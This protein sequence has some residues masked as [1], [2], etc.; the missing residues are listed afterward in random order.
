MWWESEAGKK[1]REG[2]ITLCRVVKEGPSE[3][4][5]FEL[6]GERRDRGSRQDMTKGTP[7]RGNRK[8]KGPEQGV[9]TVC[10]WK[11][12]EASAAGQ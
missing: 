5:A 11:S 7:G 8:S 2:N 9:Y 10:L 3:K 4:V 1:D 6:N 12:K